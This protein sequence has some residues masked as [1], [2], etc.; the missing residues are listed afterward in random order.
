V[1][2]S[3][4]FAHQNTSRAIQLAQEALGEIH[5]TDLKLQASLYSTLYRAYGMEGDIEKSTLAY[6]ECLRRA[7]A[8]GEY[9]LLSN[10]TM[11]RAFDLCQY[12]RFDEA[13]GDC[14]AIIAA[15]DRLKKKV[16]YPAG[17]SYIG[18]AGIYLERYDLETAEETLLQGLEL[19]RQGATDGLYRL[20]PVDSLLQA[21]GD[22]EGAGEKLRWLEQNFQRRDFTL[23]AQQVSVWLAMGDIA[24]AS[25]LVSPILE[26]L[27]ESPYAHKLPRIAAE[28]FKLSLA[29]IY[30]AQGEIERA[31]LLLDEIQATVEP[32]KRFGRLMEVHLLRALALQ[33]QAGGDIPPRRSHPGRAL[34][35]AGTAGF[36]LLFLSRPDLIR[37]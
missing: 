15:G 35:L 4:F 17:P 23:A 31:H 36:V 10:T 24:G 8:A 7:V 32:G 12:G 16:F 25:R 28:A 11:V 19:C 34:D 18:L 14:L 3:S 13:A 5:E 29:R 1:Y 22:L 37:C 30:I 21:K 26:I 27:G 20:H 2:L 6:R 9:R 33:S